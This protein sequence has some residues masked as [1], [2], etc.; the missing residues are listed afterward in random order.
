MC[1]NLLPLQDLISYMRRIAELAAK[2][3][4]Y[5][6]VLTKFDRLETGSGP[7]GEIS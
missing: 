2:G 3:A 6:T 7:E 4:R 5:L 1:G